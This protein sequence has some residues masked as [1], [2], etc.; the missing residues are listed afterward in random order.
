MKRTFHLIITFLLVISL[1]S[2]C[3]SEISTLDKIKQRGTLIVL[4]TNRATTYHYDRDNNLSGPEYDMTAD[5]AKNLGVAVEYKV[6]NSTNDV[7]VALRNHEGDIAAAGLTITPA[8]QNEFD[9]GPV[10]QE[11]EEYLVCHRKHARIKN[12]EDMKGINVTIAA[13]TSFI[14]TM[15]NYPELSLTVS[16][17]HDTAELLAQVATKEIECT[18]S[19]STL[20]SIERR[21]LTNLMNKYTLAKA[22]KLAWMLNTDCQDLQDAI[23]TWFATFKE[24]GQLNEMLNKYYGFVEIFD[25]VDTHKFLRRIKTRLPPY[26]NFFLEAA[27][28]NNISPSL[29]AAQSYQESHWNRKAKSPTGVRGLMMLTQPVAKSLGV[30]NRLHASQ[31]IFAGAK[32]HAKMK[33]MVGQIAEPDRTWLA[34]AAYNIGRGH[35]QD[36]QKLARK[37]GKDSNKWHEIKEILPLLAKKQYYKDLRYGYARGNEPVQYVMRIRGYNELLHDYFSPQKR[38]QN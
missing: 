13:G 30:T 28:K 37:M 15:A 35:F 23:N 8:R 29:L 24:N 1:L 27:K 22:T 5:F 16:D 31:N 26:K 7:I 10:Y 2:A 3:S 17:Q 6:Y 20:Y 19:D 9:F 38:N 25:Y 14:K 4:T 36:A 33:K 12:R 34:L 21:Y 18:V 32:F 11:T